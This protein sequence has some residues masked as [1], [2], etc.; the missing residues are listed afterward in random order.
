MDLLVVDSDFI[1]SLRRVS[2]ISRKYG[3]GIATKC[4]LFLTP[5]CLKIQRSPGGRANDGILTPFTM[6]RCCAT[7]RTSNGLKSCWSDHISRWPLELKEGK[8][9]VVCFSVLR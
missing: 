5:T 3:V 2:A 8:S 7:N 1:L 6:P 4:G 9:C